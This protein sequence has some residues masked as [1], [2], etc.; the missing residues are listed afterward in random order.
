M[1]DVVDDEEGGEGGGGC[2]H[3]PVYNTKYKRQRPPIVSS[4]TLPIYG[5]LVPPVS[6]TKSG[7]D[8]EIFSRGWGVLP[9]KIS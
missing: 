7:L 3:V 2:W 8:L 9:Y 1:A 4:I 5:G 6:C